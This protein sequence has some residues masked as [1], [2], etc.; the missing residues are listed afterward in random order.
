MYQPSLYYGSCA[1]CGVRQTLADLSYNDGLCLGCFY[2]ILE[3]ENEQL[4]EDE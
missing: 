2:D 1:I 4:G 3:E